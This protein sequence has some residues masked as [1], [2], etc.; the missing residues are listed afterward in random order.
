[1][2]TAEDLVSTC[3]S[4]HAPLGSTCR[5]RGAG[6]C[7]A[8]DADLTCSRHSRIPW[9]REQLEEL[10]SCAKR[11]LGFPPRS[12][13]RAQLVP[14]HAEQAASGSDTEKR[15]GEDPAS[16]L[17][18]RWIRKMSYE[19]RS[20]RLAYAMTRPI[21]SSHFRTPSPARD[22]PENPMIAKPWTKVSRANSFEIVALHTEFLRRLD[23][24]ERRAKDPGACHSS[25]KPDG[26]SPRRPWTDSPNRN[27][28]TVS[29][30]KVAGPAHPWTSWTRAL[31]EQGH[32]RCRRTSGAES[33]DGAPGACSRSL[34]PMSPSRRALPSPPP[35]A[36]LSS[37][38]TTSTEAQAACCTTFSA[39]SLAAHL[40][41]R[42]PHTLDDT[43]G[44][45]LGHRHTPSR[46]V[47]RPEL[48]LKNWRGGRLRKA[49][50]GVIRKMSLCE[51]QPKRY[52]REL[53]NHG[54]LEQTGKPV[55]LAYDSVASLESTVEVAWD[56][57]TKE[58][59]HAAREMKHEQQPAVGSH[60]TAT[61][62]LV[63]DATHER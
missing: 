18:R 5:F 4:T 22:T 35:S 38:T 48:G 13:E 42:F 16:G 47:A 33:R 32:E 63:Q 7:L 17:T 6:V 52:D 25:L 2:T 1:M 55:S 58:R 37:T 41:L 46:N 51:S 43:L 29:I 56:G 45:G 15:R 50:N 39:F 10:A 24:D 49:K 54:S 14:L 27:R 40:P 53:Q 59:H 61:A 20:L 44:N 3:Q 30:R 8:R 12:E 60:I 19:A 62:L 21:P 9:L 28:K 31:W 26:L 23:Y 36:T 57:G 34:P 11:H